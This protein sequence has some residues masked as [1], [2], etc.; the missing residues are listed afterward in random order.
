MKTKVTTKDL[1]GDLKNFPIEVVEKM[2]QRQYEQTNKMDITV[3]QKDK[4][5]DKNHKGFHWSDTVEG[6]S[7]WDDV[8]RYENFDVFFERYPLSKNVYI[9]GDEKLYNNVIKTLEKRGGIN[10]TNLVGDGNCIY[11]I[12]PITNRIEICINGEEKLYNI[13]TSTFEQLEPDK[14]IVELTIQEIAEKLG[15]DVEL[16]RIKK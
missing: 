2:L 8:I 11:Y 6:L 14:I 4:S 15:I 16:L 13:I 7:F 10:A 3:F 1:I 9:F 5:T 12:D